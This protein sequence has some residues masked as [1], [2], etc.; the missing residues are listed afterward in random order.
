MENPKAKKSAKGRRDSTQTPRS[1]RT[2]VETFRELICITDVRTDGSE[3]GDL[4]ASPQPLN[5][6]LSHLRIQIR[7]R[8]EL[9]KALIYQIR[10]QKTRQYTLF[11]K[12]IKLKTTVA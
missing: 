5:K 1:R 12:E 3:R 6:C 7:R 4:A 9:M 8:T 2:R 11:Y 10:T